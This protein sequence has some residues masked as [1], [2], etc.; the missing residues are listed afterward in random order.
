MMTSSYAM[1]SA[2]CSHRLRLNGPGR[3]GPA[4]LVHWRLRQMPTETGARRCITPCSWSNHLLGSFLH[5]FVW[6]MVLGAAPGHH[7]QI[8][9]SRRCYLFEKCS[10]G[11]VFKSCTTLK[12]LSLINYQI[13]HGPD[14]ACD[15]IQTQ[16][17]ACMSIADRT[18]FFIDSTARFPSSVRKYVF[19]AGAG[20]FLHREA[21][22][23]PWQRGKE[24]ANRPLS[25]PNQLAAALEGVRSSISRHSRFLSTLR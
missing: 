5:W 25:A 2:I 9:S 3:A 17:S 24:S 15:H 19:L 22:S 11:E 21:S 20:V 18:G 7:L 8:N 1:S 6:S 14:P 16:P 4:G 13:N 23:S 10:G 12:A